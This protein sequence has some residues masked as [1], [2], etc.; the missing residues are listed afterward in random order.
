MRLSQ[1]AVHEETHIHRSFVNELND[2]RVA[3]SSPQSP[4]QHTS[5]LPSFHHVSSP[6]PRSSPPVYEDDD[7]PGFY[8]SA[9]PCLPEDDPNDIFD[10]YSG[11]YGAQMPSPAEPGYEEEQS[12]AG[13]SEADTEEFQ[14]KG[15]GEN[16]G[17]GEG[18]GNDNVRADATAQREE[19]DFGLPELEDLTENESLQLRTAH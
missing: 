14:G 8:P 19:V 3:P 2:V 11:P 17:D 7:L 13:S 6:L 18:H 4:T 10:D 5:D 12:E 15:D 16:D 1:A 9:G